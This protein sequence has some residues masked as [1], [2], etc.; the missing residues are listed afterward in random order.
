[1]YG[2]AND[3]KVYHCF[4]S[5]QFNDESTKINF[6]VETKAFDFG[7]PFRYKNGGEI[8]LDI[9]SSTGN[10]VTVSAAIDG[11]SYTS[12]GTC[13]ATDK[14]HLDSLGKFR[15]IKF[16]FQNDATS[17]EQLIINGFRV[18]TLPEEYW[19]E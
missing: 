11:G 17:T 9:G 12:L 1:M 4:K 16:K 7:Q 6:Q 18:V 13:T 3:G 14:F 10:T 5:T 19:S 15:S 8:E 2:D